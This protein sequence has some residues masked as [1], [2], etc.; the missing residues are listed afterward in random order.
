M[1]CVSAIH[2]VS[3]LAKERIFGFLL[4]F[5]FSEFLFDFDLREGLDDIAYLDI[6]E[7]HQ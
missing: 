1:S 5:H 2:R 3:L 7:V 4:T 6:V